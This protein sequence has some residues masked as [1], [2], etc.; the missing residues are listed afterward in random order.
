MT[1]CALNTEQTQSQIPNEPSFICL[2]EGSHPHPTN[3]DKYFVC[4]NGK[5]HAFICSPGMHFDKRTGQ[6]DIPDVVK[7]E[8]NSEQELWSD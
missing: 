8:R 2:S 3:C 1:D 7:C 6:C 5:P 4:A